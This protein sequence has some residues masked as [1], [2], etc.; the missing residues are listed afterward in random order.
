MKTT[1][2]ALGLLALAASGAHATTEPVRDRYGRTI[3]YMRSDSDGRVTVTDCYG[4]TLGTAS[5]R[6]T[7]DRFG[8]RILDSNLPGILVQRSTCIQPAARDAPN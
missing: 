8:A 4:S 3:A 1:L 2:L 6:G 5:D 7:F